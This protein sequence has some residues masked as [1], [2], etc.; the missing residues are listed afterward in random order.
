MPA[1]SITKIF[2]LFCGRKR[3]NELRRLANNAL[4][5]AELASLT[6]FKF[7]LLPIYERCNELVDVEQGTTKSY[8]ATKGSNKFFFA[9]FQSRLFALA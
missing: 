6:I 7:Q 9:N 5:I 2:G 4:K 3:S 8:V 1:L